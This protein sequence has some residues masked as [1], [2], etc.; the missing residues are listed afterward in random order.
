MARLLLISKQNYQLEILQL[1]VN[2]MKLVIQNGYTTSFLVS[3]DLSKNS[4]RNPEDKKNTVVEEAQVPEI[5]RSTDVVMTEAVASSPPLPESQNVAEPTLG[6]EPPKPT[7]GDVTVTI[8]AERE[9]GEI[10]MNIE[11][12]AAA[13]GVAPLPQDLQQDDVVTKETSSVRGFRY[14]WISLLF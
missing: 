7:G 11:G 4:A 10:E 14:C 2:L 8:A 3:A 9:E 12:P 1:L 5:A 6:P 13:V